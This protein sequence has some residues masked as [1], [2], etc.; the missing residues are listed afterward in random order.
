MADIKFSEFP[1]ATTSKDSD[2]IAILQDGVNKMI[3]SPVLESKIINKTVSRVIEQGGASLNLINPIS[4]VPT[5]ADLAT[6]TPTPNV[7]DAYQVALDGLVYVY[8]ESGFQAE[9]EGFKVQPEPIGIVE[10]GNQNAVSGNEVYQNIINKKNIDSLNLYIDLDFNEYIKNDYV[11]DSEGAVFPFGGFNTVSFLKLPFCTNLHFS[12]NTDS[13]DSKYICFYDSNKTVLKIIKV[14]SGLQSVDVP[15]NAYYLSFTIKMPSESANPNVSLKA[16]SELDYILGF[17]DQQISSYDRFIIDKNPYKIDGAGFSSIGDLLYYPDY[18]CVNMIPK[19]GAKSVVVD[20]IRKSEDKSKYFV[21]KN[22]KNVVVKVDEIINIPF[23]VDLLESCAFFGFTIQDPYESDLY[24]LENV[25]FSVINEKDTLLHFNQK[26][27]GKN[28]T[29]FSDSISWYDGKPFGEETKE[30][31]DIAV[32]FASYYRYFL[33][34]NVD[35]QGRSGW[36]MT[37]ILSV[38]QSY[39]YTNTDIVTLR[40]GANDHRKGVSLGAIQPIGSVF[41]TNTYIGAM[42]KAVEHMLAQ[43]ESLKIILISPLKGWFTQNGTPDVPNLYKGEYEISVDFVNATKEVAEL[44]SLPFVDIY[45][46]SMIN[47]ITKNIYIV[48]P[49]I[50]PYFLHPS[51]LGYKRICRYLLDKI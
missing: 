41:D 37:Q 12:G 33:G 2:E 20:K 30:S 24:S 47:Y 4:V 5:Y 17:N 35:N 43:K 23:N 8:T 18:Y 11:L 32:G 31:G 39:N 19:F 16:N 51:N 46:N 26:L 15:K 28:I 21:Q 38:I 7:N 34:A 45:H 22:S 6:I 36:D 1:K 42:Q 40:S 44:Y 3:A 27:K 50:T 48:D 10:G 14:V 13:V 29:D 25:V 49:D 9:G